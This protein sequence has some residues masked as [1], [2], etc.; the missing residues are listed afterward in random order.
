M[1]DIRSV[2]VWLRFDA[3][4]GYNLTDSECRYSSTNSSHKKS[5]EG[6]TQRLLRLTNGKFMMKESSDPEEA[7]DDDQGGSVTGEESRDGEDSEAEEAEIWKV[8]LIL[9]GW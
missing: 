9:H 7:D 6:E 5:E 2:R 3:W 4:L 1:E 8:R